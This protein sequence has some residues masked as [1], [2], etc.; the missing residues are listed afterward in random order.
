[1]RINHTNLSRLIVYGTASIRLSE[2]RADATHKWKA[3]VR[4]YGNG[5]ISHFIRSVT[6]KIHETFPNPTRSVDTSPFEIEEMG[7]GEFTIQGKL[8]FV[9]VHEKPLYFLIGL[10][11]HR[12]IYTTAIGDVEYPSGWVINERMDSVIF[13]TPTSVMYKLVSSNQ[14]KEMSEEV[15]EKAENEKQRILAAIDHVLD[16]LVG[17]SR[18]TK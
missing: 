18:H 14:E 15:W 13:H 4:G 2:T 6:F 17:L 16:K 12:E 7:W 9:D 10:K 11:L 3:Y 8:Y 1:M 5:D